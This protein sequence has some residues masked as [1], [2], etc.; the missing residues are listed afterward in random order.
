[1][2]RQHIEQQTQMVTKVINKSSSLP[3]VKKYKVTMKNHSP[4]IR[5]AKSKNA[6]DICNWQ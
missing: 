6:D 2:K 1:M 5:V 4:P 3:V